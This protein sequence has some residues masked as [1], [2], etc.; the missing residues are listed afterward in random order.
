MAVYNDTATVDLGEV[1]GREHEVHIH[2]ALPTYHAYIVFANL[3]SLRE[4]G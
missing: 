2:Q 3:K 4:F 1:F